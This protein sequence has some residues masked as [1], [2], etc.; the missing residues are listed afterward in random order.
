MAATVRN[1]YYPILTGRLVVE[2]DDIVIDATSFEAVSSS[3]GS[4]V[5][6]ASMLAFVRELQDRRDRQPDVL[7][8]AEWQAKTI[9]GELLGAGRDRTTAR[10]LQERAGCCP[11]APR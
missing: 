8:P 6:P 2:V 1:Y 4:E 3:L 5:V 11:F 10:G 7:L 9:T